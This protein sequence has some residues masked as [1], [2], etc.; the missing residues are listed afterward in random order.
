MARILAIATGRLSRAMMRE[1]TT[2]WHEVAVRRRRHRRLGVKLASAASLR[3]LLRV[4][5]GWLD[6]QRGRKLARLRVV[7]LW[8]KH[9]RLQLAGAFKQ[10]HLQVWKPGG[11]DLVGLVSYGIMGLF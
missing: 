7:Q 11:S 5:N 2:A 3:C 4:F 1:V 10:W 9:E 6:W 8:N